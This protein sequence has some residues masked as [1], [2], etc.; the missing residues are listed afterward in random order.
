MG[1]PG[2]AVQ[3][4]RADGTSFVLEASIACTDADGERLMTAVLRDLTIPLALERERRGRELAE[5]ASRIKSEQLGQISH[6]LKT[7]LNA[8]IGF[9][10]LMLDVPAAAERPPNERRWIMLIR[11][12]GM[13][14]LRVID[15]LTELSRV[16]AGLV[17]LSIEPVDARDLATSVL[18]LMSGIAAEAGV[19][20]S[21]DPSRDTAP[22]WV[23]ADKQRL[24]Q[25]LLNLCSNAIK[26]NRR[27]GSVRMVVAARDDGSAVLQ[28]VD[29]GV[30]LDGEQLSHL[31]EPFNRLGR[32]GGAVE[33]SGLGLVLSRSLVQA[34]GGRLEVHSMPGQ[35]ST[36]GVVLAPA[37]LTRAE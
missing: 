4:L 20:L 23:L 30:G 21:L 18:E 19:S 37:P 15:D 12:A 10:S 2:N 31:F 24:R 29:S 8:V 33:G 35:G 25:V 11:D 36:F 9:S 27:G 32:E 28:V 6:E 5:S 17:R 14:M 1:R 13:H 16:D 34:M 22:L 3:G 26:Y 7:P